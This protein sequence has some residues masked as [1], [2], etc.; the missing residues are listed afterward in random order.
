M[1][2]ARCVQCHA[3]KPKLMPEAPKGVLL[4]SKDAV[5]QNALKIYQQA[6]QQKAMPIGNITNI[7]DEER[8]VLGA[9]YE[10]GAKTQ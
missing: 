3:A 6:V 2:Q 8:A 1:L 10:A 4:D 7:T 5:A 9:W